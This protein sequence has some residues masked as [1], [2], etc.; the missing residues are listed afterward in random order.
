MMS[1]VSRDVTALLHAWADGDEGAL[2]QLLPLVD[3]ELRRL[4]RGLMRGERPEHTL[5]PT[6]LVNEA[7]VRLMDAR[8]IHWIDRAHF[9]GIAA[10][11]MR[12]VLVDHARARAY[13]KRGADATHGPWER[14]L[15]VASDATS[16]NVIA[17][18]RALEGL[19]AVDPRQARV[20]ELRF[21]GGLSV[22][23]T[24]DILHM[25][26]DSIR[27]DW[28]LAKAWLSRELGGA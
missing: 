2:E 6:A 5:Q 8:N 21:F 19:A 17:V 10:R 9:I 26:S 4:A 12:R 24:A 13:K 18:D 22:D 16:L 3:A 28:R 23:E 14:A 11:L 27:R 7:F 25:S 20:V 1:A 15:A